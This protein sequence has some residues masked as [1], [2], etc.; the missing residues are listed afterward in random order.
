[1]NLCQHCKKPAQLYLCTDCTNLLANMLDEI[2]WL[3]NELD[4]RIQKLD[5][6]SIGTIGRTRRP[7]ELD[8]MDFDAAEEARKIRKTLLHWVN[9]ITQRHTGRTPPGLATVDTKDLARWL[10]TNV[11]AIA[12]LDLARKGRHPLYDDINTLVG[13]NQQGGQ[14]VKAIN[15]IQK[16]LVG[17]CPTITGRHR[18]GT[19]RQCGQV[20][21]ADTYDRVVTCLVC[22]QDIDVKKNRERAA[23]DRDLHTKSSLLEV[24]ANIDEPVTEHQVDAWIAAKRLRPRGYR[25]D[26]TIRE[27]RLNEHDEPVYSVERARKLRRRDNNLRTRQRTRA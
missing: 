27:F 26:G 3:L 17:P 1:V 21:F 9:T 19:P 25:I 8:V 22:K 20:L 11:K 24:L 5:R 12:R 2:P 14:L 7:E 23:A 15:P 4:A 18:N 13:T 16:H 6:I 10:H